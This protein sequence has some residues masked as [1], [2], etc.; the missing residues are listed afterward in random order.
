MTTQLQASVEDAQRDNDYFTATVVGLP[1]ELTLG[2][3]FTARKLSKHPTI[4]VDADTA[5]VWHSD[6]AR[7]MLLQNLKS[8]SKA[9]GI[10]FKAGTFARKP[11]DITGLL[12]FLLGFCFCAAVFFLYLNQ[13]ALLQLFNF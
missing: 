3:V 5:A 12:Y 1:V 7:A 4:T 10:P 6:G 2:K 11:R 13:A 9:L 8:S